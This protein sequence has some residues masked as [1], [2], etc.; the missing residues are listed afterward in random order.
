MNFSAFY[1]LF[2]KER[3]HYIHK[4]QIGNMEY[5]SAYESVVDADNKRLAF[6]NLP[7]FIKS[8]ELRSELFNLILTGIN[9][10]LFMI[11]IAIFVSVI[12]S[13]K[14]TQPLRLIENKLQKTRL[15]SHSSEIEYNKND[16]IGSL[17]K[18]YNK[19]LLD[20]EKSAELLAQSERE[21]AWR[22]MARQ[23]A[24]EI[25]NPL[26][27]MKLSIQFLLRRYDDQSRI[28]ENI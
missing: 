12:I 27:P 16:E 15:G 18:V 6:I 17:I 25:K 24:H 13:N 9:L 4:E 26:T 1:Q 14:I 10:H 22:E 28:G 20:L 11:L 5:L 23:V 3:T 7:Y 8:Q 21:S 19:M 2:H